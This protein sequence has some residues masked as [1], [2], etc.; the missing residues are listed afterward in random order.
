MFG[1]V[2][3]TEAASALILLAAGLGG[4][5]MFVRRRGAAAAERDR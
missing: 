5:A 2:F 3:G 4:L 1:D